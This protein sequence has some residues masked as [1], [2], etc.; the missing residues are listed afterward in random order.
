MTFLSNFFQQM[1]QSK[2]NTININGN[3]NI[4][5]QDSN[6]KSITTTIEEIAK[7]FT[8]EKDKQIDLLKQMLA[9][10]RKI[11]KLSDN[12]IRSLENQIA[13][14][15]GEVKQK[16]EQ[17]KLFAF[18]LNNPQVSARKDLYNDAIK[19]FVNGNLVGAISKL[20]DIKLKQELLEIEKTEQKAAISR[21]EL[22]DT[23]MLKARML[24]IAN[25]FI[26][27]E[28][29]LLKGLE[30]Y[31][32]WHSLISVSQFYKIRNEMD[33]AETYLVK[34]LNVAKDDYERATTLN[35]LGFIYG[36]NNDINEAKQA[37]E[38][39]L[40][41]RRILSNE[42]F[43]K[44]GYDLAETLNNLAALKNKENQLLNAEKLYL[45]SLEIIEKLSKPSESSRLKGNILNNLALIYRKNQDWD[46]SE[47]YHLEAGKI[48]KEFSLD[49][50]LASLGELAGSYNN[51]AVLY[52]NNQKVIQ[53]QEYYFK[54]L[55]IR[56]DL[57]K[58]N[59][60]SYLMELGE[61]LSNI[62][63]LYATISDYSNTQKYYDWALEIK[64]E[65]AKLYPQ[66]YSV[67][68]AGTLINYST[69]Y[70]RNNTE[71]NKSLSLAR[72][73]YCKAKKYV[74]EIHKAKAF[75]IEASNLVK[76]WGM[77]PKQYLKCI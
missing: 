22:S 50:T 8:T 64:R 59:P 61:T 21:R 41:I 20:D 58:K 38:K 6:G 75:C 9:D 42:D 27:A 1:F 43:L 23:F 35:D 2:S 72:E 65:R 77:N 74:S 31:H 60:K 12:E 26:E 63:N 25:E 68:L 15:Q 62:G 66:Q 34:A 7:I 69:F 54:A 4:V 56:Q 53:A 18:D 48:Y 76:S 28:S 46:Q 11:E 49:N 17:I 24:E 51:L 14:L 39:S 13:T 32:S 16:E 40:N 73:A 47:K 37:L 44:F 57:A 70:R 71:R 33:K 36:E 5:Y 29:T 10:K 45:E 30:I 67:N 52:Y 19:L 55:K 3:E